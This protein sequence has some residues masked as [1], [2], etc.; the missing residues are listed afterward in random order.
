MQE[1]RLEIRLLDINGRDSGTMSGYDIEQARQDTIG[2]IDQR[3]DF[4]ID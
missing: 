2:I 4:P 1:Y 3:A